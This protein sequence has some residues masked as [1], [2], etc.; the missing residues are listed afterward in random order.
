MSDNFFRD[1]VQELQDEDTS[2]AADGNGSAEFSGF[3]DTGSYSL[4]ALISGSIYGGVP[5][6]KITGLAGEQ[7]TGKTFF[8]L[9]ILKNFLDRDPRAGVIYFDSESAVTQDMMKTRGVDP[10][11]VVISEPDTVQDFKTKALRFLDAYMA[12]PESKRPPMIFVLDSLGQLS[13]SKEM[14]DSTEGKDTR[15][16]TR[17]QTIKAAFR[18]LTLKC[19]RAR[20]PFIVTNHVYAMVGSYVPQQELSGG[21]GLKYAA[22][23]IITLSKSKDKDKDGQ[24]SGAIIKAKTYKSRLSK[25]NQQGT[26]LITFTSGLDRYYGLLD[27]AEKYLIF[28][29]VGKKYEVA[30]G[31][32]V[33]ESEILKNPEKYYTPAVLAKIEEA[34]NKEYRY[35]HGEVQFNHEVVSDEEV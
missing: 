30:E 11:R 31:V 23:T 34:A 35:G 7:A 9:G 33:F 24:V 5:D 12:K 18:V 28:K 15:D 10:S 29:K 20:V 22:S 4:N 3:I 13:T 27:L 1:L 2:I 8:V 6:N 32:T 21:S 19:A 26:T 17:T 14:E 25:E 16:M